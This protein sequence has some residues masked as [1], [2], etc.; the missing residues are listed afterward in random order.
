MCGPA[1]VHW[2]FYVE[3]YCLFLKTGLRSRRHPWSGLSRVVLFTAYLSQLSFKFDLKEELEDL[4]LE[5]RGD[6]VLENESMF[7]NC[8]FF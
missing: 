2:T 4:N 1:W 8:K 5:R 6:E 3:R 7:E